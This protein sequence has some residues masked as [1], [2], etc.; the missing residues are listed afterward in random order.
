MDVAAEHAASHAVWRRLAI[1][2]QATA[3]P[4]PEA[5]VVLVGL[6]PGSRHE[7]GA[8]MFSVAGG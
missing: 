2:Y 1:A 7:L 6:P 4:S 8:L 5:G 3:R